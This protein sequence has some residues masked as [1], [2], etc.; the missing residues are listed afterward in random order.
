MSLCSN[1]KLAYLLRDLIDS[2]IHS[3]KQ[4][5]IE[6][7]QSASYSAGYQEYCSRQDRNGQYC[8]IIGAQ[9]L[10]VRCDKYI[11]YLAKGLGF[12][13]CKNNEKPLKGLS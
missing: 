10:R 12:S 3:F 13:F 8:N 9:D 7:L 5:L 11:L 2:F 1:L 6:H 4:S